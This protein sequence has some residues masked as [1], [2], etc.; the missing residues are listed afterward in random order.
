MK[1][2]V[3]ILTFTVLGLTSLKAQISFSCNYRNNCFWNKVTE[4]FGNCNGYEESSLFVINKAET[5]FT[6][7]I[8]SMKSTYYVTSNEYDE[9]K[10]VWTYYVTSDVGNKYMFVFDPKNK[11]IRALYIK[12]GESILI[13]YS[14]KAIF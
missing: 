4:K 2:T 11:Q 9:E 13:L 8:E 5:M 14:V 3:L 12:D 1:K 7:T 6:H 10:K